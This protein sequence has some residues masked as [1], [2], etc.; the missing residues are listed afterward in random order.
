MGVHYLVAHWPESMETLLQQTRE[1][2]RLRPW[3]AGGQP[4]KSCLRKVLLLQR[5]FLHIM[6]M[7]DIANWSI[8][9]WP[10]EPLCPPGTQPVDKFHF[11]LRIWHCHPCFIPRYV[12][13]TDMNTSLIIDVLSRYGQFLFT[14]H[15]LNY[16]VRDRREYEAVGYEQVPSGGKI[17]IVLLQI[18]SSYP[19]TLVR[20]LKILMRSRHPW[21]TCFQSVSRQTGEQ[22]TQH[23]R[24]PS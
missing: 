10:G 6:H 2:L 8:H 23:F 14:W 19:L 21:P 4:R 18:R 16:S 9:R 20:Y 7:M 3:W 22:K 12:L 24:Q 13:Q 1:D 5:D 11:G 15:L 17:F